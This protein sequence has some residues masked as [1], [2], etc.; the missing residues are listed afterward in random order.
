MKLAMAL[1]HY[2]PYGGLQRDFARIAREAV[3]RGHEV[4]ALVSDWQ[5]DT[6]DGV[7]VQRCWPPGRR[8]NSTGW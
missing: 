6:I 8:E 4:V 5:G 1:Y 2:F 7:T 3:R